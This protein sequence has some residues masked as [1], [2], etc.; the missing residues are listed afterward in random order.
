MIINCYDLNDK[1]FN[2]RNKVFQLERLITS[3]KRELMEENLKISRAVELV[4]E[5]GANWFKLALANMKYCFLR[6][7]EKK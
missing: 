2:Q 1:L 7:S 4:F 5:I 6:V 3:G